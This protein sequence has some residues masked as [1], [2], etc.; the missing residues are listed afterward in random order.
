[1]SDYRN[2]ISRNTIERY[3]SEGR[4]FDMNISSALSKAWEYA[5]NNVGTTLLIGL[6]F[7]LN[8]LPRGRAVGVSQLTKI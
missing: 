6:V 4:S 2:A 5:T 1:M 8:E 7:S 3:I